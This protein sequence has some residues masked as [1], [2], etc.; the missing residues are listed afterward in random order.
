MPHCTQSLQIDYTTFEPPEKTPIQPSSFSAVQYTQRCCPPTCT[1]RCC[2]PAC[3]IRYSQHGAPP[4]KSPSK[5][6]ITISLSTSSLNQFCRPSCE[7]DPPVPGPSTCYHQP[8]FHPSLYYEACCFPLTVPVPPGC[9]IT[10]LKPIS[11][12]PKF[13]PRQPPYESCPPPCEPQWPCSLSIPSCPPCPCPSPCEPCTPYNLSRPCC[14]PPGDPG[15][16]PCTPATP[17]NQSLPNCSP[18]CEPRAAPCDSCPPPCEPCASPCDPCK[19]CANCYVCPSPCSP[20]TMP[21]GPCPC[22]LPCSPCTMPCG[23]CPCSPPCHPCPTPCD[24]CCLPPSDQLNKPCNSNQSPSDSSPPPCNPCI[25]PPCGRCPPRPC[26]TS[27]Q[28]KPCTPCHHSST[29]GDPPCSPCGSPL[30]QPCLHYDSPCDSLSSDEECPSLSNFWESAGVSGPTL[31]YNIPE[32]SVPTPIQ[33]PSP[34]PPPPCKSP[35][36]CLPPFCQRPWVNPCIANRNPYCCRDA[37]CTLCNCIPCNCTSC[38]CDPCKTCDTECNTY[39]CCDAACSPCCPCDRACSPCPL[40]ESKDEACG[41]GCPCSPLKDPCHPTYDIFHQ[42]CAFPKE[43]VKFI[44]VWDPAD[45]ELQ[46]KECRCP[47]QARCRGV[48]LDGQEVRSC[49]RYARRGMSCK[50]DKGSGAVSR[51]EQLEQMMK[52]WRLPHMRIEPIHALSLFESN[53]IPFSDSTSDLCIQDLNEV[54][55]VQSCSLTCSMIPM[56]GE[57]KDP[58]LCCRPFCKHWLPKEAPCCYDGPC[59]ANCFNHPPGMK[60]RRPYISSLPVDI[61]IQ[62]THI[63]MRYSNFYNNYNI[64]EMAVRR[65]RDAIRLGN[66]NLTTDTCRTPSRYFGTTLDGTSPQFRN[67]DLQYHWSVCN[68]ENFNIHAPPGYKSALIKVPGEFGTTPKEIVVYSRKK[69]RSAT[70]QNAYYPKCL[71][72]P[73]FEPTEES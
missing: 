65:R 31:C 36:I 53:C 18:P 58:G 57:N 67:I 55:E 24:P 30:F 35:R 61:P 5:T 12:Q 41:P 38:E 15:S 7:P 59:K 52:I 33:C 9:H 22:S 44:M 54:D 56:E 2:Q 40:S 60:S 13:L 73:V 4:S 21:C 62:A 64:D 23:P 19:P 69:K 51:D 70:I 66:T 32:T 20:C 46:S 27:A 11:M 16:S 1:A 48:T 6:S 39:A 8:T 3:P 29:C 49:R 25:P 14:L 72:M 47:R 37:P 42:E 71:Y 34:P 63:R 50:C 43:P 45:R 26:D 17:C 28:Y 68:N 10:P